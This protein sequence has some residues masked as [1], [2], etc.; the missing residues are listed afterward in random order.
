MDT[1]EH[2]LKLLSIG[3][4][5]Q[6]GLVTFYS[7]IFFAYVGVMGAVMFTALKEAAKSGS[8]ANQVPGWLFPLLGTL[9][10]AVLLVIVASGL[11]LLY[12]GLALRRRKHYI[13]LLVMAGLSCFAMPY[14]TLLG[15]FTIL[16]LQRPSAK[17]LFGRAPAFPPAL[18]QQ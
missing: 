1:T 13:F 7:L 11:C 18:P 4:Y 6:G 2:D 8:S 9:I 10:T 14:G 3:Y 12:A 15:I 16:V 17:A 5:V